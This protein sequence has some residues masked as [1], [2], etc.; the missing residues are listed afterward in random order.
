MI[1]F[2]YNR[3]IPN[4]IPFSSLK[5]FGIVNGGYRV[6]L[7]PFSVSALTRLLNSI[8]LH[9]ST[10]FSLLLRCSRKNRGR[11]PCPC[12]PGFGGRVCIVW[13]HA[14]SLAILL[15]SSLWSDIIFLS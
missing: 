5:M 7:L 2:A 10:F 8:R 4:L 9:G 12:L 11:D 6:A 15:Y 13:F 14:L 3:P 1:A